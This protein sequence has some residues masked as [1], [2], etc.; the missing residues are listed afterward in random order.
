M[1]SRLLLI[2]LLWAISSDATHIVGGAFSLQ[3]RSGQTYTLTLK[4]LRDCLNGQAPFDAPAT[5]GLFDKSTHRLMQTFQLDLDSQS[6]L[7]SL[8]AGCPNFNNPNCTEVGIYTTLVTLSP[9]RYNNT[10]GYYFSYQRCC[11]NGIINNIVDPGDAGIAIYMEIPSPRLLINS[12]P[13]FSA[14]PNVL[15]CA[16]FETTYNFNFTDADNDL[17]RYSMVTPI[18]GNLDRNN[19]QS[20][21]PSEGPYPLINWRSGFSNNQQIIGNPSLSIDEQTGTIKVSP[22]STGVFVVAIKVEEIRNGSVIGE[23][24][25]E[26]QLTVNNCPQPIPSLSF[27]DT[28]GNPTSNRVVIQVPQS[29]NCI[30]IV[31][32]DVTDSLWLTV[33]MVKGD[34]TFQLPIENTKVGFRRVTNR[35]CWPGDCGINKKDTIQL[36]VEVK[37]NGCPFPNKNSGTIMVVFNPMPLVNA[38]DLLCMT[39]IDNKETVLYWGDSTGNNPNFSRYILYRSVAN[40]PFAPIDSF[41]DKSIRSY[42]DYNTPDYAVTNYQYVMRGKNTCEWE[43]KP[44]DTLGTFQQLK[45]IPD[46]QQIIVATVFEKKKVKITWP[47]SKELDFAEYLI[48]KKKQSDSGYRWIRTNTNLTDT[49]AVDEDVNVDEESFCYHVVMKDTCDNFGPMGT[50]ACTIV[51][52]GNSLPFKNKLDWDQYTYWKEGVERYELWSQSPGDLNYELAGTT[53][54]IDSS[55]MDNN[56]NTANYQFTYY[57]VAYNNQPIVAQNGNGPAMPFY[58]AASFSNEVT[59]WQRPRVIAPNVFTPNNDLLNDTWDVKDV[60]VKN[61]LVQV[62]NKWGQMVFESTDKLNKWDGTDL[63]GKEYPSDVYVYRIIYSGFDNRSYNLQGNVT[64]LR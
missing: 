39:L 35:V 18:N 49:F 36:L 51:L 11:R 6:L 61:Y 44:S 16:G 57:V 47:K 52:K 58:D 37:D 64:L 4:V 9:T 22:I 3:H 56:L 31:S 33:S 26:L 34:S 50:S 15:L 20:S 7:P 23:V 59:L 14:N 43:G 60:F 63:K 25:L 12:T 13:D 8:A 53:K 19:P 2:S 29:R 41:T 32:E 27:R 21:T 1:K 40:S 5:V 42:H 46:Q 28:L 45:F 38:T 55:F 24:H 30:D 48:Y 17:L 62:Y 54:G 10:D